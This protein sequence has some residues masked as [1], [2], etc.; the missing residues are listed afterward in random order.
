[1]TVEAAVGGMIETHWLRVVECVLAVYEP[2]TVE[3]RSKA[4]GT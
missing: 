4:G 2:Y 1:M 3:Q